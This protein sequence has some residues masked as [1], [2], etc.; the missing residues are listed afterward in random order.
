MSIFG[1][2]DSGSSDSSSEEPPFGQETWDQIGEMEEYAEKNPEGFKEY[3]EDLDRINEE[4]QSE[5]LGE[6]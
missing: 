4:R 3:G 1:D 2:G 6:I 5:G